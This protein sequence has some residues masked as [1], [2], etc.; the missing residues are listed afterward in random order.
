MRRQE[1]HPH[2]ASIWHVTAR[3]DVA[4]PLFPPEVGGTGL[5]Y[6]RQI[7]LSSW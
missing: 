3:M 6:L 2:H 5:E 7:S 4:L 1:W